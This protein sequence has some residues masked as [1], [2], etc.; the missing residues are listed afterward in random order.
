MAWQPNTRD[1]CLFRCVSVVETVMKLNRTLASAQ[2]HN[3]FDTFPGSPAI[4]QTIGFFGGRG[5][6]CVMQLAS[7]ALQKFLFRI[8]EV[9]CLIPYKVSGEQ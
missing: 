9:V 7:L 5:G 6:I 1:I 3:W 2:Q 8:Q 4:K